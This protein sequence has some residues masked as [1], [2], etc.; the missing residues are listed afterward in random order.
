MK[1]P[2]DKTASALEQN[3]PRAFYKKVMRCL[4]GSDIDSARSLCLNQQCKPKLG[5]LLVSSG[6]LRAEDLEA[7]LMV[8]EH[9]ELR[10]L[11]IGKLLVIA[12]CLSLDEL[13]HYLALQKTLRPQTE[14][15]IWGQGLVEK[16]LITQEQL[17]IAL[18]DSICRSVTLRQAI[19]NRGWLSADK[20]VEL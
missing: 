2:D 19:I 9:N 15:E 13:R 5:Q 1:P 3:A 10:K 7:M 20:L 14:Q 17:F 8:H 6:R 16:H 18:H 12:G 4:S 11:P